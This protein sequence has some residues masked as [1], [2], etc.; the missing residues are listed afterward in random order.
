MLVEHSEIVDRD[1]EID[2]RNY[3]TAAA[4]IEYVLKGDGVE[5]YR[6]H[7]TFQGFR[8]ARGHPR[9][10]CRGSSIEFVPISSVS[11]ATGASS[12]ATRW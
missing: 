2:N 6:P 4:Q 10:R 12:A 5:A 9:R 3:R 11:E 8:Y 7:F 1:R